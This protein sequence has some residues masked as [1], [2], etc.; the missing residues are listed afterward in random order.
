MIARKLHLPSESDESSFRAGTVNDDRARSEAPSRA[1]MPDAFHS[2]PSRV[3]WN[4]M[5]SQIMGARLGDL[6]Y[7][8]A[9]KSRKPK[10]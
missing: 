9:N 1:G 5:G 3:A 2:L 8:R 7:Y 4:A 6:K 10:T